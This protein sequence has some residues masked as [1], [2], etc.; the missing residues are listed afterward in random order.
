MFEPLW[1]E[2]LEQHLKNWWKKNI[3]MKPEI[4]QDKKTW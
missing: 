4:Q 1:E 3:F 2:L